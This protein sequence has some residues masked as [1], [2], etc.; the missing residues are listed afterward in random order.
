[1]NNMIFGESATQFLAIATTII[2]SAMGLAYFPQAYKIIKR[3]S[4][5]DI[6]LVLFGTLAIGITLWLLYGLAID[7]Y[8]LIIANVIG[9]LG[10]YSV[11]FLALK[12]RKICKK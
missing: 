8:P 2:G 12:Y 1:M 10:T 6:S 11:I 9:V 7:N 3:K 4:S 5:E